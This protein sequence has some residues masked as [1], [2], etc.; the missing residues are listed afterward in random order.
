MPNTDV[1][2]YVIRIVVI[3]KSP[4]PNSTFPVWQPPRILLIIRRNDVI[5]DNFPG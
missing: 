4:I 1:R 2:D 3:G 5:D